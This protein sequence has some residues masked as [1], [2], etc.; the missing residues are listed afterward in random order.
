MEVRGVCS[1][2]ELVLILFFLRARE[3]LVVGHVDLVCTTGQIIR[4]AP[5]RRFVLH[6]DN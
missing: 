3:H 2:I 6:A 1:G 4:W 5:L